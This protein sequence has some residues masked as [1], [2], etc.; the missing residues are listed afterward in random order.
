MATTGKIM[1]FYSD[2]AMTTVAF[3]RTKIKAISND[4]GVGL[5]AILEGLLPL[6]GGKMTG[7]LRFTSGVHYGDTLPTD[8]T[9]GRIFFKR[10]T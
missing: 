6:S 3:P 2:K 10:V 7:S 4:S 5:D 9:V 1:D 8:A